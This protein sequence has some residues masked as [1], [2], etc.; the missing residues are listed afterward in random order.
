MFILITIFSPTF[1]LFFLSIYHHQ[2]REQQHKFERI[3]KKQSVQFSKTY[4]HPDTLDHLI[5]HYI[6]IMINIPFII[7]TLYIIGYASFWSVEVSISQSIIM[8]MS[9]V[10]IVG[11]KYL[12]SVIGHPHIGYVNEHFIKFITKFI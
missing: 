1:I 10:V 4:F 9:C 6:N 8:M 2:C 7:I 5:F 11:N 12:C 3:L